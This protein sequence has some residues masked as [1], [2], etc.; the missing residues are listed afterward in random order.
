MKDH[1]QKQECGWLID[2]VNELREFARRNGL[3]NSERDLEFLAFTIDAE[4]TALSFLEAQQHR[5]AN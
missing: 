4:L 2:V 3:P 5:K 1:S